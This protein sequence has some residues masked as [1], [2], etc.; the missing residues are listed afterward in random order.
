[1]KKC[2][3][4][5]YHS[6]RKRENHRVKKGFYVFCLSQF[7]MNNQTIYVKMSPENLSV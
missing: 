4:D 3:S 1:M 6:Y 7:K 2:D 5:F